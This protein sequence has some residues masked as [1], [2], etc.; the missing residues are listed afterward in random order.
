MNI[1]AQELFLVKKNMK[2]GETKPQTAPT[3]TTE[4]PVSSPVAKMSALEA[5]AQSNI[6]FQAV[7]MPHF[8]KSL[9]D[10]A[11]EAAMTGMA[12]LMLATSTGGLQSCSPG[13]DIVQQE[14]NVTIDMDAFMA[15]MQTIIDNQKAQLEEQKL[16]NELLRLNNEILLENQSILMDLYKQGKL[17]LEQVTALQ[18]TVATGLSA[19]YAQLKE[20][21][22]TQ[23][24]I[25]ATVQEIN[26]KFADVQDRLAKGEITFEQAMDEIAGILGSID[27]SLKAIYNKL[28][29]Y[30][31]ILY[32]LVDLGKLTLDEA[33]ETNA[34][35][36]DAYAL[37]EK[38]LISQT[39]FNKMI[40][41][42][43]VENNVYNKL[44]LEQMKKNGMTEREAVNAINKLIAEVKDGKKTYEQGVA[45]IMKLL[46]S[47]DETL[48]DVLAEL[49]GLRKDLREFRKEYANTERVQIDLLF[50]SLVED[51]K[52]TALQDSILNNQKGMAED[53]AAIKV[54]SDSMVVVLKDDSKYNE[55]MNTLKNMDQNSQEFYNEVEAWAAIGVDI[56]DILLKHAQDSKLGQQAI[57]GSINANTMAVLNNGAKLS[58]ISTGLCIITKYLP[59]LDTS[60]IEAKLDEL[61][62]AV[63]NNTD[64]T[65]NNTEV[66]SKGLDEVGAKLDA[67]LAKLDKVIDG[68]GALATNYADMK[69]NWGAALAMLGDIT[70]D[71][72]EI[73]ANQVAG[74]EVLVK[75]EANM[76]RLESAQ[77]LANSY[78]YISLQKQD[79][80]QEAM[81]N[82][83]G[84]GGMTQAE[85]KEAVKE[86][87]PELFGDI[88]ALLAEVRDDVAN[89]DETVGRIEDKLAQQKD[90]AAQLDRL[91]NIND[92]IYNFLKNA[93][94][95]DPA[96]RE[97]L[98]TIIKNQEQFKCDCEC[99]KDSGKTDESVEDLEDIF[100]TGNQAAI[101]QDEMYDA[102][103]AMMKANPNLFS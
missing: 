55:L 36:D 39:E 13:D 4:P 12:A 27:N 22:A 29:S 30:E 60:D 85:F 54:N 6:A 43:L 69:E 78:L 72:K 25:L 103:V 3:P 101:N 17:T 9:A 1:N 71:L 35:F 94:F 51:K 38:G 2:F 48:K 89:M 80:L 46:G 99:G 77:Q 41:S 56:R 88:E 81:E 91:I 90:Y 50:R 42:A 31:D 66:V 87:A 63:D 86:L 20:N 44:M 32:K 98:D 73:K 7:K 102:F 76:R 18:S 68:M 97:K 5:Q 74:N 45:E 75:I 10:K 84:A 83:E 40:F 26:E 34:K 37:L 28:N 92:S 61:K 82:I 49:K 14:V 15:A 65:N 96:V 64:A 62:A 16:T 23:S 11:R 100:G 59:N 53:L 33:Q 70:N 19:V 52:Q 58:Q 93:D 8:N 57:I 95:T 21:G 24:E 79:K 47:I 67:I